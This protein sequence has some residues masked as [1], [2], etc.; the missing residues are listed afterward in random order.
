MRAAQLATNEPLASTS[1]QP[2]GAGNGDGRTAIGKGQ[3]RST[4]QNCMYETPLYDMRSAR[5]VRKDS[6]REWRACSP[7]SNVHS[8]A[9]K[10]RHAGNVDV[11][12]KHQ[13]SLLLEVNRVG[14]T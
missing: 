11:T 13:E 7:S 12:W 1:P 5:N 10:S 14:C 8:S 9:Q 4:C 6:P 2:L 3:K